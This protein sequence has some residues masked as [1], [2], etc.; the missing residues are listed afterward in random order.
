MSAVVALPCVIYA[1]GF[2]PVW[3]FTAVLAAVAV[4][5]SE[6]LF[7]MSEPEAH[8]G[9]R[10]AIHMTT[11]GFFASIYLR[12]IML[13][14]FIGAMWLLVPLSLMMFLRPIPDPSFTALIGRGLMASVYPSIPLAMLLAFRLRPAGEFWVF[15][16]LAVVFATDTGAF[17]C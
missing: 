2:G 11:L 1:V 8:F 13:L 17:Y 14:P 6:K 4:K 3:L 7:R 10:I 9:I 15:F 5:A 16:L 12:Q